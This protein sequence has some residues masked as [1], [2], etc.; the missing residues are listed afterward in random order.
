MNVEAIV[1]ILDRDG[2]LEL[3]N[4][5]RTYGYED[6]VNEID[7]DKLWSSPDKFGED[8]W[9]LTNS[10]V[11]GEILG[12]IGRIDNPRPWP[13]DVANSDAAIW[14]VCA[15]YQPIH[16]FAYDW[17]I[18]IREDCLIKQASRIAAFLPPSHQPLMSSAQYATMLLK[19]S[20]AAFYFHEHFHHKVESF[21]V[22]LHVVSGVSKYLPYKKNVYR[23]YLRTDDCLEEALANADSFLRFQSRPYTSIL[24]QKIIHAV[25][26]Y[27]S[28]T[29]PFDPPGYRMATNYLSSASFVAGSHLLQSQI[30]EA[31][32]L[33]LKNPNDWTASP[34]MMR[35]FFNFK[36][37]IYSVVSRGNRTVLPTKI[38]PKSCSTQ[39]LIKIFQ[40][41][42]YSIVQGGK[43]S[44]VKLRNA[45][46]ETMIIPGNRK[47]LSIGVLNSALKSIGLSIGDLSTLGV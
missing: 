8:P 36:S 13:S 31:T 39:T 16:F 24:D 44:H 42:G 1:S 11:I 14:D 4:E 35:S 12:G 46:G 2:A 10:D 32:N 19:A 5:E 25:R 38:L 6:E 23:R 18:F 21:G 34:Q 41:R 29:F 30:L 9:L 22:R 45:V 3:D 47:D 27:L 40:S 26:D 7:W 33:P 28:A 37:N 20:F 15:W 43:G 17:G